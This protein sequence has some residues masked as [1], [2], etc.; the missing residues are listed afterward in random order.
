MDLMPRSMSSG[1]IKQP[2]HGWLFPQ[3]GFFGVLDFYG[4]TMAV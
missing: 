1:T 2:C 3:F 4:A